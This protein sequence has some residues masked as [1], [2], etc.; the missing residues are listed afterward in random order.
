MD[1]PTG[2]YAKLKMSEKERQ[3]PNVFTYTWNLK[4]NITKQ[5]TS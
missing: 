2:Y 1:G 3:I 5:K 4:T